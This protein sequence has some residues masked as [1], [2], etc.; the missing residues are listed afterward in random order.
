M[1]AIK[2][3]CIVSVYWEKNSVF[4]NFLHDKRPLDEI[5]LYLCDKAL[6]CVYIK[7]F[8]SKVG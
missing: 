6:L 5:I 4:R 3:N 7:S 1:L 2:N 8:L